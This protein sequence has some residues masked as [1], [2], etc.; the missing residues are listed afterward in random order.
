MSFQLEPLRTSDFVDELS[1]GERAYFKDQGFPYASL[2]LKSDATML[3]LFGKVVVPTNG[4]LKPK[5]LMEAISNLAECHY[6]LSDESKQDAER[7]KKFLQICVEE[8]YSCWW[9]D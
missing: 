3:R 7:I 9:S 2:V 8:G 6:Y 5:A 4:I 1:E